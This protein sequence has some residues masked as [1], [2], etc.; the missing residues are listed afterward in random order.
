LRG[1]H[2]TRHDL[3]EDLRL[4]LHSDDFKRIQSARL[5]RSGG[6]SFICK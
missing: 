6:I 2:I 1:N 3:E 4:D 5:E